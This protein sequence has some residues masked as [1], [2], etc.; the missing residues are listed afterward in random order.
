MLALVVVGVV[1]PA[2]EASAQFDLSRAL[3]SLLGGAPAAE[4]QPTKSGYELLAESAPQLS[5]ITGVWLY[6][7]VGLENLSVNPLAD[8]AIPQV[9]AYL[10][11]ELRGARVSAGFYGL[12]VRRN[13]V[14]YL[15]Y[16]D[17]IY[18]GKFTYN[19]DDASLT[20]STKIEGVPV[21]VDGYLKIEDGRLVVLLDANALLSALVKAFPEYRTD[22][23]V[24]SAQSILKNFTG[25]Y[26]ALRHSR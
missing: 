2:T 9:E 4:G 21:S 15:S 25:V 16:G 20:L 14:V 5:K 10:L 22:Q 18:D 26:I 13:G 17:E 3:N 23:T 6:H 12:T 11:A 19:A 1:T 24:V 7:S 8:I